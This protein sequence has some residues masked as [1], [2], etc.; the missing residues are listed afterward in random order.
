MGG[1]IERSCARS[2][3]C[4]AGDGGVLAAGVGGIILAAT[5]GAPGVGCG[6]AAPSVGRGA[7]GATGAV[8]PATGFGGAGVGAAGAAGFG[9]NVGVGVAAIGG[10]IGDGA[11]AG[12]RWP[13]WARVRPITL[14]RESSVVR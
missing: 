12:F 2:P 13:A 1:T 10:A 4:A 7:T 5:A 9:C 6:T 11:A 8:G 14:I 3:A